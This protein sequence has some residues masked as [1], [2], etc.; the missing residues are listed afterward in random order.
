MAGDRGGW[1]RALWVPVVGVVMVLIIWMWDRAL[2]NGTIEKGT[3]PLL[4]GSYDRDST[5]ISMELVIVH[6]SLHHSPSPKP[7]HHH[8][9][10]FQ[11]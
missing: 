1:D 3:S 10:V 6:S 5:P 7:R 2:V 4:F 9:E 11:F 8:D